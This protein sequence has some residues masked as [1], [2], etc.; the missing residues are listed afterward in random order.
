MSLMIR[1]LFLWNSAGFT[2]FD[3]RFPA[4]AD[5]VPNEAAT[6]QGGDEQ[7]LQTGGTQTG[8]TGGTPVPHEATWCHILNPEPS[9]LDT[10]VPRSLRRVPLRGR[11]PLRQRGIKSARQRGRTIRPF[12]R[13]R[14]ELRGVAE[15]RRT[16]SSTS[17]R[18]IA[19]A[20]AIG[21]TGFAAPRRNSRR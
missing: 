2:F 18:S 9:R 12:S 14:G 21:R 5:S 15:P 7:R 11:E 19:A 6:W 16:R 1:P 3:G 10:S 4:M 13:P 20:R 17:R 8:T